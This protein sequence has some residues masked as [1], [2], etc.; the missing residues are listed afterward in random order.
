MK[1]CALQTNLKDE[2]SSE[3]YTLFISSQTNCPLLRDYIDFLLSWNAKFCAEFE[4]RLTEAA[5]FLS[6]NIYEEE[7]KNHHDI[8]D[9]IKK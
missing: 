7:K 1:I 5:S 8:I 6:M 9:V 2:M 3:E 4:N